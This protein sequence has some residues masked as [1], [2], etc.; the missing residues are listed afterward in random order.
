MSRK[1][2]FKT[3][4]F[5]LLIFLSLVLIVIPFFHSGFFPT[6]D[7]IQV[8]RIFE[9]TQSLKFGDFPPRWSA[10]LLY[11]YGYPLF[12]FYSPLAYLI[13]AVLSFLGLNFLLATKAVFVLS[14]IIGAT[15]VFFL[16][17]KWFGNWPA[18]VSAIAFSYAPYRAVDV[19]V[20]GNLAE[21]FSFSL[22][23]WVWLINL[24]L[25]DA[26]KKEGWAILLAVFL[27]ML[28]LSHNISCFIFLILLFSFNL[29]YLFFG[30]GENKG[31]S[32]FHIIGAS[33]L[34]LGLSCFYWLPL[35]YETRFVALDK[36]VGASS[37]SRYFLTPKQIWDSPWGFGGFIEKNAMSLQLGKL[38]IIFS[39]L[40]VFLNLIF[41][42][43]F[44]R[45]IFWLFFFFLAM[46]FLE[47]RLSDPIWKALP[48]LGLLQFPWRFHVATT[49]LGA[50]MAG[51]VFYLYKEK[52]GKFYRILAAGTIA[53]LIWGNFLYFRPSR[54]WSTAYV[55]ETTTWDDEY[56][57]KWVK[58]KPKDYAESKVMIIKGEVKVEEES[59]G[60][61]KKE[62]VVDSRTEPAVVRIAQV[63][64]PGWKAFIDGRETVVN[65]G[66][67]SGLMEIAVPLGK[68]K[69]VFRFERTPWRKFSD[70]ISL[71]SWVIA[72]SWGIFFW[73]REAGSAKET[74]NHKIA[75]DT[76]KEIWQKVP[77]DYYEQGTKRNIGQK[78]WH[79]R[80][81]AVV[82][83]AVR[84]LSPLK[85]L[86]VGSNGGVLTGKLA[87]I[88]PQAKVFGVDVYAKAVKYAQSKYP[89]IS[90]KVADA[91]KL[92]FKGKEFDLIFCLETL[93]HIV[94]PPKALSE[95]KRCLKDN[96]RAVISM[97]SG[98][99]LF[100][101]IW[102]FW[103]R[104]G[105]GRVWDGSH[106]W[107]FNRQKLKKM[108]LEEGFAIESE[109]VSHLGMAV[110]FVIK[111][112]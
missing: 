10:N 63:F 86:D 83:E 76:L 9:M 21:F 112:R 29:F 69:V 45:L 35:I 24:K 81:L 74:D 42:T 93:E 44:R 20:R 59:W 106:L 97:D 70:T 111:K 46:T 41:K 5:L 75:P 37:Y 7:D 12:L 31:S 16:V 105:R 26:K 18:L 87:R 40:S 51:A 85:V 34:A 52:V 1:P 109:R 108:I 56:L 73:K 90:F 22:F 2:F 39:F 43:K 99:G 62:F 60:Y 28:F 82:K 38:L 64:Y 14:F 15:G 23:P 36:F 30:Q 72:L 17:K 55:S 89:S 53:L 57:P 78:I 3:F 79:L 32:L 50:V 101:L 33:V 95:M 67:K 110:T 27:A 11:G 47:I 84:N 88:F 58:E 92:P 102:F 107:K 25:L 68:N 61:L 77:V 91:Q 71:L 19:Y 94:S 6:H 13:G 96:G 98:S 54:Y 80:K 4:F 8:V 66:N 65:Y 103:I 104:F 48:V 49:F 100:N